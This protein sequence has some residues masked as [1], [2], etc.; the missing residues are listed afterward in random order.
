MK[1]IKK[2]FFGYCRAICCYFYSLVQSLRGLPAM[3]PIEVKIIKDVLSSFKK[4][5]IRILEWGGGRSTLYFAK[6]LRSLGI[7][8]EW[9]SI[10]NSKQ[11]RDVVQEKLDKNN[12]G[13]K[14]KLFLFEF[15]P[16][17]MKPGWDF[18]N[19]NPKGFGPQE[20]NEK[21]YI[22][23]PSSLGIKFDIIIV[24]ARFRRRCLIEAQKI[25]APEGIV[26]LHDAQKEH[27]HSPL[28]SYKFGKFFDSGYLYSH[29]V[30]SRNK[31]WIGSKE[32]HK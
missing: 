16:F 12:L 4:E 30:R 1:N 14:V 24:D 8:F 29:G 5:K 2:R 18:G 11:W 9:C 26:I 28:N 32:D 22:S 31:I 15:I 13:D 6:Y 20:K 21:D 27:Y 25:L 3:T 23:Y 19:P 10:E 17:W 7:D